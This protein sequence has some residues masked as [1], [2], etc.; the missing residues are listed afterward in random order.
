[1]NP[2]RLVFLIVLLA[3]VAY[4]VHYASQATEPTEFDT[5]VEAAERPLVAGEPKDLRVISI[6]HNQIERIVRL[7]RKESGDWRMEEPLVDF[8][9]PSIARSLVVL[10]FGKDWQPAPEDWQHR[11]EAELG[12]DPPRHS[13]ELEFADPADNQVLEIGVQDLSGDYYYAQVNG[14]RIR[15]GLGTRNMLARPPSD[16]RD[17]RVVQTPQAVRR[18]DFVP[19]EGQELSFIRKND[20]WYLDKPLQGPLS[21]LARNGIA[22]FLGSRAEML[23]EEGATKEVL[24]NAKTADKVILHLPRTKREVALMEGVALVE[25]RVFPVPVR[26]MEFT[27]F[28]ET[29]EDLLSDL[30]LDFEPREV[31]SVLLVRGEE[32]LILRRQPAGW[33]GPGGIFAGEEDRRLGRPADRGFLLA[34]NLVKFA[35]ELKR[36]PSVDRPGGNPDGKIRLSRSREPIERGSQNLWWWNTPNGL[37]VA[38]ATSNFGVQVEGPLVTVLDGLFERFTSSQTGGKE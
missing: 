37:V 21:P 20:K 26:T 6:H 28:H 18:L 12:L 7:A 31:V 14:K 35:G 15:L 33:S 9:E 36:T 8:A 30:L 23:P 19:Q 32:E 3:A 13:V 24:E 5:P 25:G 16:F 10:L 4:A 11:S 34:Q 2:T 17:K 38:E 27:V 29:P 22:R 1:M